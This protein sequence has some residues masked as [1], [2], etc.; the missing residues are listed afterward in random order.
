M[1][2][3]DSVL[4]AI[5]SMR[6]FT[7]MAKDS[8]V[9]YDEDIIKG[10]GWTLKSHCDKEQNEFYMGLLETNLELTNEKF[11]EIEDEVE[12]N[13][14]FGVHIH[15]SEWQ[16]VMLVSGALRIEYLNA[17]TELYGKGSHIIPP[18]LPHRIVRPKGYGK[19]KIMAVIVTIPKDIGFD[20]PKET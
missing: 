19:R 17:A 12:N 16:Y 14:N 1:T 5:S 11:I 10:G 7:E 4:D 20:P 2:I 6:S 13:P 15:L 9:S 3:P 18:G 8:G